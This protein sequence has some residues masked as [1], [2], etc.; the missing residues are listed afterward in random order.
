MGFVTTLV[1]QPRGNRHEQGCGTHG[2][3]L[4]I[5]CGSSCHDGIEKPDIAMSCPRS[6]W[7]N[8]SPCVLPSRRFAGHLSRSWKLNLGGTRFAFA[9]E[10]KPTR[11]WV[12]PGANSQGSGERPLAPCVSLTHAGFE[13][14]EA[15]QPVVTA[16]N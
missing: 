1:A 7:N 13:Y 4:R 12:F 15:A 2:A 3:D 6:S 8:G 11:Q 10:Y 9:L 14:F 16:F 5:L